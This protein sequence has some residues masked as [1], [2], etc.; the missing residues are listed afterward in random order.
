[1]RNKSCG[2]TTALWITALLPACCLALR[3]EPDRAKIRVQTEQIEQMVVARDVDGL[4]RMLSVAEFPC[5][6][7]A[8][9][10]LSVFG[11]ERALPELKRLNL[12]YGGWRDSYADADVSGVFA[13]AI[14]RIL[15]RGLPEKQQIEALCD[16]LDGKGPAVPDAIAPDRITLNGVPQEFRKRLDLNLWVGKSVAVEL[17]KFDDPAI[18]TRLRSRENMGIASYAVWREVR[19][20]DVESAIVRCQ[21]IA[22]DEE[23]VQSEGAIRCLEKF[24]P[25]GV[26]ALDQLAREGYAE[27]ITVL[28]HQKDNPEIFHLLCWHLANNRNSWV[29]SNVVFALPLSASHSSQVEL[30][31]ALV[32][33]LYDPTGSTR[34]NAATA[35]S[36]RAYPQN[37]AYFDQI[38]DSLLIALK[39]PDP[40]VRAPIRKGLER[41]GC[42]R[43]D[44]VVP[45]SPPVRT[46]LEERSRMPP[47]V[48]QRL[49]VKI[50]PMEKDAAKYLKDG[51]PEKAIELYEELLKLKPG[52]E[53]YQ[54]ALELARAYAQAAAQATETWY[55]DAP[56][57][58]IKGRYS[59]VLARKTLNVSTMKEEHELAQSLGKPYEGWSARWVGLPARLLPNDPRATDQFVKA[60]QL[61]EH[62][63]QHYPANEW[64]VFSSKETIGTLKEALTGDNRYHC[65]SLI[66]LFAA[67]VEQMVD[68]THRTDVRWV[69]EQRRTDPLREA[70]IRFCTQDKATYDLLDVIVERCGQTDPK[71]VQMAKAAKTRI[72]AP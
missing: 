49:R 5:K 12:A 59:Y 63:V 40:D 68:S 27:A 17:D 11:D 55:P 9:Q 15:T 1:M 50:A 2:L 6:E 56:Y 62:I 29:R 20:M 54:K 69:F 36:N 23:R 57:I 70:V 30:L 10:H 58:G 26:K 71:I 28:G 3:V 42:Q 47:T 72:S 32:G 65:L 16:L 66:E 61:Y 53:S 48:Q 31:K 45:D 38:E 24:G 13:V 34:R 18:V 8:A 21:Q 39:H 7:L 19:G 33:A 51:P 64:L 14:C 41:L 37:K 52:H 22:R 60:L 4:V 44:A 46:D 43:L 35:L 25:A 67:P